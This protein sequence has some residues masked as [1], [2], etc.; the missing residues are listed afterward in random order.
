[1]NNADVV[2]MEKIKRVVKSARTYDSPID[3]LNAIAAATKKIK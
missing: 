1:M 2:R 3:Y